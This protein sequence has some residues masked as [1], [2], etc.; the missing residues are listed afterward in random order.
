MYVSHNTTINKRKPIEVP[1]KAP[2]HGSCLLH[3]SK[4]PFHTY[5]LYPG[6]APGEVAV[7][8]EGEVGQPA[9]HVHHANSGRAFCDYYNNHFRN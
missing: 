7:C 9:A 8:G 3:Q 1:A 2:S 5:C 4:S 6:K